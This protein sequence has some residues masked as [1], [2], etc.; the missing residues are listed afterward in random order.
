M[1]SRH[2]RSAKGSPFG[3]I[4]GARVKAAESFC[5]T[6]PQYIYSG[7][8][9]PVDVDHDLHVVSMC[10]Q[11]IIPAHLFKSTSNGS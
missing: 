6:E 9:T 4:R 3:D 5:F 8:P 11:Q 1:M 10:T 2:T 7:G